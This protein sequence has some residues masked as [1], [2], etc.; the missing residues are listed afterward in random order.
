MQEVKG[1]G[2]APPSAFEHALYDYLHF[3]PTNNSTSASRLHACLLE[4]F[5]AFLSIAAASFQ[6]SQQRRRRRKNHSK[7][8]MQALM[9]PK[10]V[11]KW[12]EVWLIP[13][14]F[15]TIKFFVFFSLTK[16]FVFHPSKSLFFFTKIIAKP[17]QQV[18][19]L[20]FWIP[21]F[22]DL[23]GTTLLN[24]GLFLVSCKFCA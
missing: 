23:S 5:F 12:R 2:D 20:L 4:N 24:V 7:Q 19:P 15:L 3:L 8:N 11:W 13:C 14:F 9:F 16:I 18:N 22:C 10:K 21:A 6:S 17:K 1:F